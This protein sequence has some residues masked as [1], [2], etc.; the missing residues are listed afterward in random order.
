MKAPWCGYLGSAG[1]NEGV[2]SVL[3]G[4]TA[5]CCRYGFQWRR[6]KVWAPTGCFL[7]TQFYQVKLQLSVEVF[8]GKQERALPLPGYLGKRVFDQHLESD[9]SKFIFMLKMLGVLGQK[10]GF[11]RIQVWTP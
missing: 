1:A 8:W 5:A 4:V 11:S 3:P 10:L 9:T 6:Q 2:A 7:G